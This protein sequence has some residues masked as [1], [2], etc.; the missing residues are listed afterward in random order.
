MPAVTVTAAVGADSRSSAGSGSAQG[1]G[2][3]WRL[4]AAA[5][6][7]G[8]SGGGKAGAV[9][10]GLAPA[11]A[12]STDAGDDGS[13]NAREGRKMKYVKSQPLPSFYKLKKAAEE[14]F[15]HCVAKFSQTCFTICK[16]NFLY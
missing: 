11:V 12:V 9:A 4:V 10:Q 15:R 7:T 14:P 13:E 2:W 6:A 5:T 8:G 1:V 16:S 3:W